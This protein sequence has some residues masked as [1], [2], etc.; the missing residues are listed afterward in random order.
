M[1]IS[2][3]EFKKPSAGISKIVTSKKVT[4]QVTQQVLRLLSACVGEMSRAELMKEVDIRDRVSFARNYL[5]PSLEKGFVEMTQPDS[6]NSPTQK[7][8]LTEKGKLI[9]EQVK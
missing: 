6:P 5:E 2:V 8:R 3:P 1:Y 4:Q 7:Y 9:L